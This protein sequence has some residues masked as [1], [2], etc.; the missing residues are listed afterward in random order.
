MTKDRRE[1]VGL[2]L[3]PESVK[4]A[5]EVAAAEGSDLSTVLRRWMALGRDAERGP[6]RTIRAGR[7]APTPGGRPAPTPAP[8]VS[9]AHGPV[10]ID[11]ATRAKLQKGRHA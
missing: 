2:R 10:Q 3:L 8:T 4:E 6:K 11:A 1:F 9:S 5:R 7:S